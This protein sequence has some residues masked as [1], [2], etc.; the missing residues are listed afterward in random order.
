M[1]E[2]RVVRDVESSISQR[3]PPVL[4]RDL[5]SYAEF[6]DSCKK[7]FEQLWRRQCPI[8]HLDEWERLRTLGS[9]AFGRV[10]LVRNKHSGQYFVMKVL[11]KAKVIRLKQAQHLRDERRALNYVN[12]PFIVSL[13]TS[14]KDFNYIF[15]VMPFVP[16][17]ELFSYLRRVGK[18]GEDQAR[19]Y[20]A[21]VVLSFEYLHNVDLIYRDLKPENILIDDKGYLKIADLGFCK[22]VKG[23]TWTLCGTPEY[24]A[25]ELILSKGYG[26]SADWW[27]FGVL[28][29]EMTAGFPPFCG[30]ETLKTYE[31]I[32]AGKYRPAPHHSADV[33][34]LIEKLLQTDLSRRI[35][36]LKDGVN[37]IKRHPWFRPTNWLAVLNKQVRAPFVP[38]FKNMGDASNYDFYEEDE[39]KTASCDKFPNDFV[40]F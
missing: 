34:D 16:G 32:V 23:R 40:D 2:A 12:F 8:G 35:G 24:L 10:V 11:E 13:V 14:F 4:F 28:I 22:V 39:L 19:F 15:L 30:S 7:E 26:K 1:S 20:A 21:Q 29:Y 33:K 38:Q 37:D 27:S 17:G 31:K 9:G 3:N 25:P 6:L 18:F 36:I 5:N